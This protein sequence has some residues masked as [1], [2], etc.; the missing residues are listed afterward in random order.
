MLLTGPLICVHSVASRTGSGEV[1]RVHIGGSTH[2]DSG[3]QTWIEALAWIDSTLIVHAGCRAFTI[4][5]PRNPRCWRS[6]EE[7]RYIASTKSN[8]TRHT[9]YFT[10]TVAGR[11]TRVNCAP[12]GIDGVTIL[13]G[14]WHARVTSNAG[15]RLLDW[16]A[17]SPR[18]IAQSHRRERRMLQ[19]TRAV[20]SLPRSTR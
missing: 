1:D 14:L 12:V 2:T 18:A 9:H 15:R 11:C 4:Q 6:Q 8:S 20:V 10:V 5:V 16:F 7:E 17:R 19:P 13:N 3:C